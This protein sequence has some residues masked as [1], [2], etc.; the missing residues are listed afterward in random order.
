MNRIQYRY[1]DDGTLLCRDT[2]V[3]DYD[4]EYYGP[5]H[6]GEIRPLVGWPTPAMRQVLDD[7]GTPTGEWIGCEPDGAVIVS[8]A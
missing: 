5:A 7:A 6:L 1:T 3:G 2:P 4:A 8:P